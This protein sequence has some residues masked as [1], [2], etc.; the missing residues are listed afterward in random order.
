M[1]AANEFQKAVYARLTASMGVPVYDHVPQGAGFP[2]VVVGEDT[3][4]PWDTKT[5]DGQEFTATI[6]VWDWRAAGRKSVKTLM[7]AVYDALHH[8]S[9]SLAMTGFAC[10]LIRCEFTQTLQEAGEGETDGENYYH[11]VMRFRALVGENG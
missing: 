8:R 11:G 10:M 6:H 1:L 3:G 4:V 7:Q 5:R 9:E 2:Y